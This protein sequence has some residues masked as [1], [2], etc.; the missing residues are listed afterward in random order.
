[1]AAARGRRFLRQS[2][3]MK[4]RKAK[5]SK[6][7]ARKPRNPLVAHAATRKAGAH[8]KSAK[9]ERRAARVRHRRDLLEC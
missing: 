2:Q 3:A 9:A 5:L 4:N 7:A 1:M 6:L 8:R